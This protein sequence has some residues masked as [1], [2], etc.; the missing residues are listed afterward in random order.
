[1]IPK[2]QLKKT[3]TRQK[4]RI[5]SGDCAPKGALALTH[6]GEMGINDYN[7]KWGGKI[8]KRLKGVRLLGG[9]FPYSGNL[10]DE[11][12]KEAKRR[13]DEMVRQSN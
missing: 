3:A 5:V 2:T 7:K 10:T 12:I 9:D 6:S 8:P 1:L 11:P 13:G 4:E